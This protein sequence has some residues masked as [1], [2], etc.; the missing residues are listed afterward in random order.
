MKM[1]IQKTELFEIDTSGERKRID[2]AF[3]DR[4]ATQKKLHKLMDLV[5]QQEWAAAEA[6]LESKWWCGRDAKCECP[7]LEFVG[8]LNSRLDSWDTYA[9]L[10]WKMT[11]YP[12]VYKVMEVK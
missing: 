12:D 10:V 2:E 8:M 6:E 3:N 7:R 1:V 9:D 4:P 11:R 5:E